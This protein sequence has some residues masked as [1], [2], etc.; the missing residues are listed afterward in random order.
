MTS[1]SK[2]RNKK[3]RA[4]ARSTPKKDLPGRAHLSK[5][6]RRSLPAR[7]KLAGEIFD[8]LGAANPNP[9]CELYYKTPFQLLVSVV[10]SAQTTD[11]MVNAC[12]QPV[13]DE[14]FSVDD[15]IQLGPD[16]LLP[17]IRRIG[18][19]PTKAKNVAK[20]A[21]LIKDLHGGEVPR[22]R[23]ELEALPGVGRKTANVVLAEI[24]HEPTMAVDT[25]V[26]RVG[27]RLG[28]HHAPTPEKAE[29]ELMEAIDRKYLPAAHHW[30]ILHGRY[31]CKAVRPDC[32]RCILNDICP[33][34][35]KARA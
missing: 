30:L 5:P 21:R 6:P 15:A 29:A 27:G 12:M 8:R 13:Y 32:D 23:E 4:A 2:S 11:K 1:P 19:A 34:L 26:F 18:F 7:R 35:G 20:L 14:G 31:T 3:S 10:L 9:H 28:L 25:H 16:G 33:S 22:H 24:W 17:I